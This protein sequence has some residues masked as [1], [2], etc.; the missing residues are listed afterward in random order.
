MFHWTI[1]RPRGQVLSNQLAREFSREGIGGRAVSENTSVNDRV[2]RRACAVLGEP[3]KRNV[4]YWH[5]ADID[6]LPANVRF[7]GKADPGRRSARVEKKSHYGQCTQK[8]KVSTSP[9][10]QLIKETI[11][12]RNYIPAIVC[13]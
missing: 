7:R 12:L 1:S 11:C 5:L 8:A 13:W 4:R 6:E 2:R 10:P 3:E 9:L